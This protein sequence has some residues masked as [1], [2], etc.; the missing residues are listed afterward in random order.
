MEVQHKRETWIGLSS[1]LFLIAMYLLFTH[2]LPNF[3][4]ND[5]LGPPSESYN[6]A[7]H[8]I[9][10]QNESMNHRTVYIYGAVHKP[11]WYEIPLSTTY[12]QLVHLAGGLHPDADWERLPEDRYINFGQRFMVPFKP[13]ASYILPRKKNLTVMAF[14]KDRLPLS[15]WEQE[16]FGNSKN[17]IDRIPKHADF[18]NS[19]EN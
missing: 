15:L 4:P 18:H 7:I 9:C 17:S 1:I 2:F 11:A 12:H 8:A 16:L 5:G 19:R 13:S 14:A 6:Q 3:I 10:T